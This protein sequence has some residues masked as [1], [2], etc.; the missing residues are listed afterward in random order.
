[1]VAHQLFISNNAINH[2]VPFGTILA[3]TPT[4]GGIATTLVNE[5]D[6]YV[7]G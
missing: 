6:S 3:G 1:V 2:Y 5:G 4:A 7:G